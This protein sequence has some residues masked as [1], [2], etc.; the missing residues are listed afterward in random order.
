[1]E[2]GIVCH[3]QRKMTKLKAF[4]FRLGTEPQKRHYC[5]INS[6]VRVTLVVW[7]TKSSDVKRN[8][9]VREVKM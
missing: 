1:M 9:S 3:K 7:E 6:I 5:N 4:H 8:D 2:M